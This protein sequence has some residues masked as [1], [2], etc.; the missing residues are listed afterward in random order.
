MHHVTVQSSFLSSGDLSP[1]FSGDFERLLDL[2]LL[3]PLLADLERDLSLDRDFALDLDWDLDLD[4]LFLGSDLD[5]ERDRD[6]D[7]DLE[8][9][10]DLGD[11]CC[12]CA[13]LE[14]DCWYSCFS[15]VVPD[16]VFD[17]ERDLDLEREADLDFER[18]R[19]LER[20]LRR[21]LLLLRLLRRLRDLDR[22]RLL[23]R[24][25]DLERE[26]DLELDERDRRRPLRRVS[27]I[28]RILR[29]FS[30][31]S[32]NLSIAFL[33]SECVAN[34]TTPSLRRCLCASAYVTSPACLI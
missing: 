11:C 12:A 1:S 8:R 21:L 28:N 18:P 9:S 23:R 34:S 25:R 33:I 14:G 16:F 17:L 4:L 22:V 3:W 5:L 30:S 6:L 32:S 13:L 10:R 20:L 31:V 7:L 2:D 26:R 24:D 19:D 27:S 15:S 29:P